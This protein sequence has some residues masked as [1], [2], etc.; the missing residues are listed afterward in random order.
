MP[1]I[2]IRGPHQFRAQVRRNGAYVTRT[3]ESRREAED[4]AR[5]TEG[6]V[7]GG[8]VVQKRTVVT[9][10]EAC[11]WFAGQIGNHPNARNERRE[12]NRPAH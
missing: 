10:A 5:I 1:S 3:F 12:R 8:E 6:K 9:L 11:A 7:T 2:Q 4:W